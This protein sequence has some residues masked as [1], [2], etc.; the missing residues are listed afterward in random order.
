M[1]WLFSLDE[2][3]ETMT[4]DIL[5]RLDSFPI[6]KKVVF[7]TSES[8][9]HANNRDVNEFQGEWDI[10]LN[11][12]DDQHPIV[13][14]YDDIIRNTMPDH[15]DASLWFFDGG[16]PRINTQEIQGRAYYNRHGYIYHP[17]YKSFYCDNESTEVALKLG[18]LIKI[19]KCIIKHNHPAIIKTEQDEL[20]KRND[21]HWN[22]DKANFYQR[23]QKGYK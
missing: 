1:T 20:Y 22:E 18:K 3:D 4:S 5:D 19:D 15:L 23:K 12:S 8:K 7:G 2:D 6:N 21:R 9:I 14:C 17:S 16:Q 11:I 10:L 13:D